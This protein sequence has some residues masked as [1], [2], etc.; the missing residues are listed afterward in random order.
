MQRLTPAAARL[1]VAG[2]LP[3][4]SFSSSRITMAI[5]VGEKFPE[6]KL[7]VCDGR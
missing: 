1:R 3:L 2:Y 5:K 7:S 6:G 4:R